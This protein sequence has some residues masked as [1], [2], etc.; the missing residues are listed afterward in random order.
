MPDPLEYTDVPFTGAGNVNGRV[1]NPISFVRIFV[2]PGAD[3]KVLGAK[4]NPATGNNLIMAFRLSGVETSTVQ[5]VSAPSRKLGRVYDD[6]K[7]F[8]GGHMFCAG[9]IKA[10]GFIQGGGNVFMD[11]T[12]DGGALDR[13][14]VSVLR[15]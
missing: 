14:V 13:I 5:V 12:D 15:L 1:W 11:I 8:A 2:D 10:T 7:D 4:F 9:P 3:P 6:S